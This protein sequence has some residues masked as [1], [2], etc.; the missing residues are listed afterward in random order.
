M[1]CSKFIKIEIFRRGLNGWGGVE[2]IVWGREGYMYCL[3]FSYCFFVGFVE[4]GLLLV[5]ESF[6]I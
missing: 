3:S 2:D 5:W 6:G 4:I 1:G